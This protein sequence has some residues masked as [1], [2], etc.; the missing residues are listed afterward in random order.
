MHISAIIL[1]HCKITHLEKKKVSKSLPQNM[2][3]HRTQSCLCQCCSFTEKA[4]VLLKCLI[5]HQQLLFVYIVRKKKKRE[6]QKLYTEYKEVT[7]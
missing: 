1:S 5:V 4:K 3:F 6:R 7:E 2:G